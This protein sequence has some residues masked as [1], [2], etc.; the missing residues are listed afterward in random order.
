MEPG[1]KFYVLRNLQAIDPHIRKRL[2]NSAYRGPILWGRW[3][4]QINASFIIDKIRY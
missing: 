3:I 2:R 1:Q 4:R